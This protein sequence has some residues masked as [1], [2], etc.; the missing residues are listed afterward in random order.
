MVEVK[1]LHKTY[2]SGLPAVNN[3]TFGIKE[4]QVL[5]LLGPNGAGKSSTFNVLTMDTQRSYGTVRML[6]EDLSKFETTKHGNKMG[7]CA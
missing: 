5:G 1:N 7:L 4:N 2:P 6:G 3:I